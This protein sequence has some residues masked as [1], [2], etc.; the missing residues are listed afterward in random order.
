MNDSR[1]EGRLLWHPEWWGKSLPPPKNIERLAD[2]HIK[3]FDWL[4]QHGLDKVV[5][6]LDPV[7]LED[8][9][10]GRRLR[11]WLES[12]EVRPPIYSTSSDMKRKNDTRRKNRG[13]LST[14]VELR[15][16]PK[17]CRVGGMT[18]GGDMFIDV[19]CQVDETPPQR[20]RQYLGRMPVMVKSRLCHLRDLTQ[21]SL[22][23]TGEEPY[24]FGG[25]FI[26][27][28]NERIV[29]LILMQRRNYVMAIRR[30]AFRKRGPGYSD[31]GVFIRCCRPDMS[32]CTVRLFYLENGQVNL[33][34]SA[35]REE[36]FIPVGIVL[37]A[38]W[39]TSDRVLYESICSAA[40]DGTEF[41]YSAR[42]ELILRKLEEQGL[43]TKGD[44]VD[45]LGKH[46]RTVVEAPGFVS[47]RAVGASLLRKFLFVHCNDDAEKAQI[48][49]FMIQKLFALVSGVC[50]EDNPDALAH[51]E[52]L[53]P[54]HILANVIKDQFETFLR[55]MKASIQGDLRYTLDKVNYTDEKYFQ[56]KMDRLLRGK[57]GGKIEYF[58]NTGNLVSKSIEIS[59]SSGFT[60]VAE[61]LNYFRYISH[62]RAVHRGA[63]YATLQTT[64][65]RKLLPESW[66][67][68][69]P[70]HTPDGAPCGLLNHL[71]AKCA[72]VI[73]EPQNQEI[74]FHSVM[75]MLV[76]FGLN[77]AM[78]SLRVPPISRYAPVLLDGRL[79]GHV[80]TDKA[81][82]FVAEVR[83]WKCERLAKL[84]S[85]TARAD[86]SE[87]GSAGGHSSLD[88]DED[89][90]ID[91]LLEIAHIPYRRGEKYP[92]IYVF[93]SSA[94]MMREVFLLG[95][96]P[97][98]D[99]KGS[100]QERYAYGK[101]MIGSL[102]QTFLNVHCPDKYIPMNAESGVDF[103]KLDAK[104]THLETSPSA[105]LSIVAS[106]TPW[107]DFN[108]SPRNMY[109]CQMAK[110]TMGTPLLSYPYRFDNKLYRLNSPQTP[111]SQTRAYSD[112]EID[113][114][115]SGTNA[116]VAVLSY[117]GYD[118]EDAMIIN[119]SSMERGF[120]HGTM[121]KSAVIEVDRKTLAFGVE[122]QAMPGRGSDRARRKPPRNG[123]GDEF[124]RMVP[125]GGLLNGKEKEEDP[126]VASQDGRAGNHGENE[127]KDMDRIDADG[128]PHVGATIWPGDNQYSVI[129]ASN[130]RSQRHA[131]KGEEVA[132]VDQVAVI[133]GGGKGIERINLKMRYNRNPVIGDKFA[134]RHGQKGI[135][136]YLYRDIDMPWCETT[137]IRPDIIFNP[138]GFPS[139]MTIGMIIESLA[140][141]AGAL[142]GEFKDA[143]PFATAHGDN[144]NLV[145]SFGSELLGCG[146]HKNGTEKLI[147]GTTGE[148]MEAEIYIGIVYY[149]RLRHMVSD[150]FQVRSTGPINNQTKQVSTLSFA[151]FSL[152]LSLSFVSL[153][154][155]E[156]A[157]T[158][159]LF[160]FLL[161]PIKGRKVG[162]GIRFGEMERD[163]LIAHGVS[164]LTYDR[165]HLSSDYFIGDVCCKCGQLITTTKKPL[166]GDQYACLLCNSTE[167]IKKVAMPY[168]FK[169]L[170]TELASV[171]IKCVL[172][173]DKYGVR[174]G[175]KH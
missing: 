75:R 92:G 86:E 115:A 116:I 55:N 82:A 136:S 168:V 133:G 63:Y 78:E 101:E 166:G 54:G 77:A 70:V 91:V 174:G 126:A 125:P 68:L 40:V 49:V 35:N 18:Y 97:A 158:I 73:Q 76:R 105:M 145:E 1:G 135:L 50:Q 100:V 13:D 155:C 98:G 106:L 130:G 151:S 122:K 171:N 139:R 46:F 27:N 138:H 143:T 6:G 94:R 142:R 36:F 32:A 114:Y 132:V 119:K 64:T 154:E 20:F 41:F 31:C 3:S 33:G 28:G 157:D 65:V 96:R 147:S 57:V 45:Y 88:V 121:Y 156:W 17:D 161:Q 108:Q 83:R 117:T 74:Y 2:P 61:K 56:T 67:F 164:Y 175:V 112:Y 51:H 113:E 127:Y 43:K 48:L 144:T 80:D 44:C 15:E 109:Q 93:T 149:Q 5:S 102:E 81:E 58:L 87:G 38:L 107:S 120:A 11:F 12:P 152:S 16:F 89:T 103:A 170:V 26:C 25:Y 47:N 129:N 150:K 23:R 79:V 140:S 162:G 30:N 60:I 7:E 99:K 160:S 53:L 169:Y 95:Q 71:A 110:Q 111:I 37:K 173:V 21:K 131:L 66:G 4:V 85:Q 10:S 8:E 128:L 118:M 29:R 24:E 165:L 134:S 72:I 84:A 22:I 14:R 137:G 148:E 62:F 159:F 52:V 9:T 167:G 153:L 104:Y 42:A 163:A 146:F 69:C 90:Q 19:L 141:K 124:P 172:D 123:F 39:E 34:F 59:Q